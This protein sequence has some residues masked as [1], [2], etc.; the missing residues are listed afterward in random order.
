MK[1]KRLDE[2]LVEKNLAATKEDALKLILGGEIFVRGQKAVS[3]AQ[4][5]DSDEEILMREKA[6][7][8]GRGGEKLA[9]AIKEF[10]IEPAGTI[11]LDIG[12]AT[13]GFVDVLLQ[14]GAKKVYAVDTA[15]GKLDLKLRE[16]PRVVVME[17]VNILGLP[18]LPEP[19]DL[20]T[21]DVSLISLRHVF[22]RL[23]K[24]LRADWEVVALF[25]PQ[26]EVSD[27]RFLKHGI[28]EDDAMREKTLNDFIAWLPENGWELLN[29]STSPI[30][31]SEGN[32]EYL[33]FIKSIK[34]QSP[35]L[36]ISNS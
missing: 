6:R 30:K 21:I 35:A 4:M 31:G 14:H 8:V 34:S 22:P 3:P 19:V 26:Y 16:D 20:I 24:F 27:K 15:K 18:A 9:H 12:S 29:K 11:C 17:G 7:Y 23:S 1:K 2:I 36:E 25:K 10:G 13:G 33:L 5:V 32:V 28:L